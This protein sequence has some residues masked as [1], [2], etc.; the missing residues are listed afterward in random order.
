[1]YAAY[2]NIVSQPLNLFL[3]FFRLK[4]SS[5]FFDTACYASIC[6][7][8]SSS[9]L[10]ILIVICLTQI[11]P[12]R[13]LKLIIIASFIFQHC[14]LSWST[15]NFIFLPLGLISLLSFPKTALCRKNAC[16]QK[17]NTDRNRTLPSK[18]SITEKKICTTSS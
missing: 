14:P 10:I 7:Q 8:Q 12:G 4:S 11:T 6:E 16:L 2:F 18:S 5:I 1:M 9:V 15:T 3:I 13:N 17:S